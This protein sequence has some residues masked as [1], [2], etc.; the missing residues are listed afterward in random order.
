MRFQRKIPQTMLRVMMSKSAATSTAEERRSF[1]VRAKEIQKEKGSIHAVD[2]LVR[3]LGLEMAFDRDEDYFAEAL[4]FHLGL[5]E[6]YS[7]RPEAMADH[8]RMSRTIPGPE[9]EHLYSDHVAITTVTREHQLHAI[10]RGIPPILV[11]CMPRSAS[12]TLTHSLARLLD[13]PV[14]HT[15]IG[16]FP[17]YFLAP[18]W[19]DVILQGGA[20]TQDHFMPNDFN[21]AVL[22]SRGRR[23]LF[24][25]IRDPRAAARSLVHWF[26]RWDNNHSLPLEDRIQRECISNYIPWLQSW[27]DCSHDPALPFRIHMIRFQEITRDLAGTVRQ[28]AGALQDEYPAMAPYAQ[29]AD[30]EEVRMH[31]DRGDD[32][33]WRSEV[34]VETRRNLWNACTPEIRELL[35][36]AP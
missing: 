11:A 21:L 35:R 36:L 29:C 20:V 16:M 22:K 6:A 7:G 33:A 27:I 4:N 28:I 9:D 25:L 1:A 30:L 5:L 15:S 10:A 2:Y 8:I 23:N 17:D 18:A 14:L 26:S 19:L 24:V 13:A 3:Q 31:F 32:D 34:G 12:A